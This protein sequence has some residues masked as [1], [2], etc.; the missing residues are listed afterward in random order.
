MVGLV[1]GIQPT[2]FHGFIKPTNVTGGPH[3]VAVV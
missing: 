3:L 2:S 1:R